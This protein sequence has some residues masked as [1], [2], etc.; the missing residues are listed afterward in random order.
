MTLRSVYE[1]TLTSTR[2]P[3]L[4]AERA[5]VTVQ[6]AKT[7]LRDEAS[8]QITRQ[9]NKPSPE[10][11]APT[12]DLQGFWQADVIAF[13]DYKGVNAQRMAI[14][15][16]LNT[17]TRFAYARP[18]L[19]KKA[20]KATEA[21]VSI[22]D[23]ADPPRM[24]C[25][26]IDNGVE[27]KGKFCTMMRERGISLETTEPYTH[28]RLARTDRF[29]R[30]L[31]KRLGEH[32]ERA[33]THRWIDALPAIVAN[34]NNTPHATLTE[35][36]GQPTTPSQVTPA[37]EVQI[38]LA[39]RRQVSKV[40]V[41]ADK[42]GIVPGETRVRVPVAKTKEGIEDG[43]AKSQRSTWTSKA[44]TVLSRN[45][46]N[47][48]I[49]DAP[50]GEV[51]VFPHYALQIEP[52]TSVAPQRAVGGPKVVI[53]VE[54]AKNRE[55]LNRS[56]ESQVAALAAPAKAKRESV[57]TEKMAALK[58]AEAKAAAA[59]T[60]KLAKADLAAIGKPKAASV[61]SDVEAKPGEP[62]RSQRLLAAEQKVKKEREKTRPQAAFLKLE[63]GVRPFCCVAPARLSQGQ[64][65]R[66]EGP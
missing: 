53:R 19:N 7:F 21:M 22:L 30:T 57:P 40:R 47:S 9:Y 36:L 1:D 29:H 11:Y 4:L 61:L 31:R 39:E 64:A 5:G 24:S 17:T 58:V 45:G 56:E 49:I 62:R 51:R 3:A 60:S 44:F 12:G 43:H 16:V 18:L 6:S 26:R 34:Y 54:R 13:K 25:L 52:A 55:S 50:P 20:D 59:K 46:P 65:G 15:T 2:D 66:S 38:R 35:L 63:R 42:L 32:F 33:D 27:F 10:N 28:Y 23:E 48:F 37:Q 14:L 8:A 41:L